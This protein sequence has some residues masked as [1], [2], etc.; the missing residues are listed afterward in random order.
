MKD[1]CYQSRAIDSILREWTRHVSTLLVLPT[2]T[3]KTYVFSRVIQERPGRAMVLAHREELINQASAHVEV[4]LGEP[5]D[6]EMADKR[7][8][9]SMFWKSRVV[10]ASKDSLH[11]KRLQWFNPKDF[12]TL[13]IDEAHHAVAGTYQRIIAHF[14]QN[15]NLRILGVTATPDRLDEKALG[16]VFESCPDEQCYE[17]AQAIDDGYL[18]PV[19]QRIVT[20]DS[21][22]FRNIRTLAGDFNPGQLDELMRQEENLHKV[23]SPV[24]KLARW[25]RTLVFASSIAHGERLAEIINRRRPNSAR[26]VC[27]ETPKEDRR[28]ILGDYRERRFQFM[29]NVGVFTEGFDDPGIGMVAIARPT[30]SRALYAQMVGRGTRPLKGVIDGLEDVQDRRDAI[31]RSPKP[32]VEILDFAGNSGKHKLVTMA[33]VL[34]GDYDQDIV[35]LAT[36]IVAKAGGQEIDVNEALRQAKTQRHDEKKRE[37]E[38]EAKQRSKII[39]EA[40]FSTRGVDPFD[41]LDIEPARVRGWE[42]ANPEGPTEPQMNT[43]AKFGIPGDGLTKRQASQLIGEC[44]KR[45][46]RGLCTFKMAN[47]LKKHGYDPD[48][49]FKAAQRVLDRLFG[50]VTA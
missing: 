35:D 24:M 22:D 42:A 43:L 15:P 31:E 13:I 14:K 33:D 40:T 39:G 11:E 37:A 6:I 8:D 16:L 50:K 17:V 28:K 21:L 27:G 5:C 45:R 49:E 10:V 44:I 12:S 19:S 41:V 1:R 38:L 4:V 7:A 3:G 34:G 46:E 25:N 9:R 36:G 2:G 47:Q 26:F 20:I 48:M 30:K 32:R 23:A 18:V 29:V